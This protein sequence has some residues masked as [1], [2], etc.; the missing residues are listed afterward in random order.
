MGLPKKWPVDRT[1]AVAMLASAERRSRCRLPIEGR[2]G[3]WAR[4]LVCRPGFDLA[5]QHLR[6]L[7]LR[8]LHSAHDLAI[9]IEE[10]AAASGREP[11]LGF[12]RLARSVHRTT[13]D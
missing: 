2:L 9:S 10:T 12:G 11:E 3:R 13:H 1:A 8:R 5:C 4:L 7:L 6:D